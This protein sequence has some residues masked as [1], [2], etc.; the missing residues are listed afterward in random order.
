M[1]DVTDVTGVA[2]VIDG[3]RRVPSG[4]GAT[5][6]VVNPATE[7]LAGRVPEC[8]RDDLDIQVVH[9]PAPS[10]VVHRPAPSNP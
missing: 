2:M 6:A 7:Q 9:R 4:P 1:T 10:Q 8:S 3:E 5:F